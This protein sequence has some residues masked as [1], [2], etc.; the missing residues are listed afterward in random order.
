MNK[1]QL[2]KRLDKRWEALKAS[3][4]GLAESEMLQPGVSGDWSVKDI[5]AHVTVW[6]GEALKHLPLIHAGERTPK[7]ADVYGGIDAFNALMVEGKKTLSLVE[8]LRQR[9][10]THRRIMDYVQSVP[11]ELYAT[12]TRFRKRL[13]FDTYGHYKLHAEGIR[14]WR[15]GR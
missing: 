13:R 7:Y 15:E 4:A 10:E 1:D 5:I 8:V 14:K 11:E 2:L 12:E 9:D 6:E 3:Y